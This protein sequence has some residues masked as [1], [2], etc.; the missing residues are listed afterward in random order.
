M[1]WTVGLGSLAVVVAVTCVPPAP[2]SAQARAPAVEIKPAAPTARTPFAEYVARMHPRIHKQWSNGYLEEW[3]RKPGSGPSDRSLV[4]NVEIVLKDDGSIDKLSLVRSSGSRPFDVAAI[5]TVYGAAPY[6]KP[7]REI[8]SANNRVY[9]HWRFYRDERQCS[10]L[11]V[12]YY[13]LDK[14]PAPAPAE[15]PPPHP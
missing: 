9:I 6:P 2:A 7:P 13:I 12:D 14:V 8:L 15:P 4:T 5:D 1:G 10:P 11:G 3:D